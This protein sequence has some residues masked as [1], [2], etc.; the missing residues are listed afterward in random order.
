LDK[1]NDIKESLLPRISVT[2]PVTV[3]MCLLALLVIGAVSYQKIRLQAFPSGW[4]WKYLWVWVENRDSSPKENDQLICRLFDEYLGTV[5]NLRR[6]RTWANKNWSNTEL[7][8]R[9]ETDMDLAYNQVMDRVE[10]MKLEL[11]PEMRDRVGIWKFNEETDQEIIWMA[12][13]APEGVEDV[14]K[15]METKIQNRLNRLDGVAKVSFWGRFRKEIMVVV[16]QERLRALQ[17]DPGDLVQS[18]QRDNFVLAGGYVR[19]GGKKYFVRSLARYKSIAELENLPLRREGELGAVKLSDVADVIYGTPP[20]HGSWRINRKEAVG[21]DIYK[22]SGANV[23]EVA[24]RVQVELKKIDAET[25]TKFNIFWNQGEAIRRSID[26]IRITALWGGLFAALVLL[27]YLRT[28]RMTAIITLAIPLCI[29]ITMSVLYAIDWSL[30]MLTMMGLMVGM[31]MVVDN[32]IVI[33]ENIYRMRAKGM[34]PHKASILG[35]SEVGLAITM[36]T[37]TTVVVFLPLMLMSGDVNLT[38]KLSRIGIPVVVSLLGSL[39]VALIFIPLAAK[40]LS[41]SRVKADPK[42]IQWMR[43]KY[44]RGLGWTLRNRRDA[45]LIVLLLLGTVYYPMQNIKQTSSRGRVHN[46]FYIRFTAP[47]FFQ[48]DEMEKLAVELEDFLESKRETYKIKTVRMSYWRTRGYIRIYLEEEPNQE[49][50]Y[51]FYK[52][53][54]K[55]VGLPLDNW[56]DRTAVIA[57]AKNNVPQFVGVKVEVQTRRGGD[58]GVSLFVYGEDIDML[59]PLSEEIRRRLE[60]IPSVISVDSDLEFAEKE[61]QILVNKDQ[62]RTYGIKA[63]DVGKTI[64]YQ[65]RGVNLPRFQSGDREIDVRLFVDEEGR[66]N[67]SQLKNFSFKSSSGSRIPLSAFASFKV[68]EGSGT[69]RREDGKMRLWIKAYTT[70]ADLKG[71]YAE[72]DQAMEGFELPRGYTWN[73]GESYS[74]FREMEDTMSFAVAMAITCVFLLMGILF[75]S[76]ILPFSVLLSIPFAFLGV[77]WTLYLTDTVM[78]EMARMGIILLI[79]VVVNNAIVLVDMINR[80]RA[81]GLDRHEAILEAGN[82]RFRPILMTTFTTVFGLFPMAVGTATMMGTPYAPLGLTMVGGLTFST[83]LTLFVVPLCY[84]YLDDLRIFLQKITSAAFKQHEQLPEAVPQP[85]DD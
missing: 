71:L 69:I 14:H 60:E 33:V 59:A 81:S 79:G 54:R 15:F 62:A 65:L 48:R 43:R 30:N 46:N 72:V 38:F 37:M 84:T 44:H 26:N 85:A 20:R 31:G 56:M 58:P 80:T 70:K 73:K 17:V 53:T 18:L 67:I 36:A 35:A 47:R 74:K 4:E 6:M 34:D 40:K 52:S 16:D 2:R 41:S 55:K 51:Q 7:A 42:S 32:A 8:F 82:N 63:Q 50:W 21:F 19:E 3:V 10:R 12:V 29:L 75:E 66:Q 45:A 5:R 9:A 77:Y 24:D 25:G 49:W 57:D 61:V 78:G 68:T 27:F 1:Q 23:V 76:F 64:A 83:V 28:V 22:E 11:P 39:F 13:S